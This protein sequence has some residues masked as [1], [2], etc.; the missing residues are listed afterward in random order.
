MLSALDAG[1]AAGGDARGTQAAALVVL[2]HLL[3]AP[4]GALGIEHTDRCARIGL[5]VLFPV[6]TCGSDALCA[7]RNSTPYVAVISAAKSTV[8]TIHL[9]LHLVA[10]GCDQR[11]M[12]ALR[13]ATWPS[14][15]SDGCYS[16]QRQSRRSSIFR[17]SSPIVK[18]TASRLSRSKNATPGLAGGLNPSRAIAMA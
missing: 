15:T 12:A 11:F 7:S 10:V 16:G 13:A 6:G 1:R 3:P 17:S 14:G 2:S 9:T 18:A 8:A 5:P 4:Y